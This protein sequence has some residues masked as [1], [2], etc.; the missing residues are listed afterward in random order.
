MTT[1]RERWLLACFVAGHALADSRL[2][3]IYERVCLEDPLEYNEIPRPFS[4]GDVE[5]SDS[6]L[7]RLA[8]GFGAIVFFDACAEDAAKLLAERDLE[9]IAELL[10]RQRGQRPSMPQTLA[11]ARELSSVFFE[12][13]ENRTA[14][15]LIRNQL[16]EHGS[17]TLHEI[18]FLLDAADG[19]TEALED[20]QQYRASFSPT[21][22]PWPDES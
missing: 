3:H 12:S 21:R 8:A 9:G 1:D 7:T 22:I 20:L 11:Y 18:D 13:A 2:G 4:D 6:L 10:E 14:V 16:L 17:L 5:R 15:E 19:D